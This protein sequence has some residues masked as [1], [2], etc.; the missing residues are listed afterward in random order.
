[1]PTITKIAI[2][3]FL[4]T[5]LSLSASLAIFAYHEVDNS[6]NDLGKATEKESTNDESNLTKIRKF[7]FIELDS[8]HCQSGYIWVDEYLWDDNF[9]YVKTWHCKMS[10]KTRSEFDVE[11]MKSIR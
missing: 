7:L 8:D 10:D 5:L 1:M 11:N 3:C 4:L 6:D 2:C 9:G